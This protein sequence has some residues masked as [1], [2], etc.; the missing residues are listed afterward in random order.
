MNT[1]KLNKYEEV[2]DNS[3]TMKLMHRPGESKESKVLYSIHQRGKHKTL[4]YMSSW[5]LMEAQ[6]SPTNPE[7]VISAELRPELCR[8]LFILSTEVS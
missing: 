8:Y 7:R 6:N 4:W 2:L 3:K 5:E 1:T